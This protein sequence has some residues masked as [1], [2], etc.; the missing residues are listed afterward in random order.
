MLFQYLTIS[1]A[2]LP[3]KYIWSKTTYCG[4]LV[5]LETRSVLSK[6]VTCFLVCNYGTLFRAKVRF[7]E[8]RHIGNFVVASNCG[9][10]E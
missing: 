3:M 6:T 8:I 5:L 2:P 9:L 10:V 1:M 7:L 4:S